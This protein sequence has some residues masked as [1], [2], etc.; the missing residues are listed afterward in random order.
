[1]IDKEN[2][3]MEEGTNLNIGVIG[4]GN[5][6]T[7]L[8][9]AFIES[10][11]V[12]PSKISITNRT[13]CKAENVKKQYSDIHVVATSSEVVNSSQIIFLCVK[14]LEIHPLLQ[15]LSN[16][17]TPNKCIVSI[18][19]PLSVEQLESIVNCQVARV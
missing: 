11:A 8:I 19:S 17:L 14:P 5:M 1:H 18:T 4:T 2:M 6:G 7:L 15:S 10:V 9:E 13:I 16:Q 12:P 3:V